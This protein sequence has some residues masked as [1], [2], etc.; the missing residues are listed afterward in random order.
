M[1][2]CLLLCCFLSLEIGGLKMGN[3]WCSWCLFYLTP[4]VTFTFR[5][6]W[7]SLNIQRVFW[8]SF[9]QYLTN[10]SFVVIC[11]HLCYQN[12]NVFVGLIAI[13][14]F[15][16]LSLVKLPKLMDIWE[17]AHFLIVEQLPWICLSLKTH[18][19]LLMIWFCFFIIPI[20]VDYAISPLK[21][22]IWQK[23]PFSY[24][25]KIKI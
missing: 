16:N 23:V 10:P 5:F 3:H 15:W 4:L 24:A 8:S 21:N 20:V 9:F 12:R 22:L 1:S 13:N 25:F 17:S 7:K 6:K 18:P 19:L 2:F 14:V 11:L